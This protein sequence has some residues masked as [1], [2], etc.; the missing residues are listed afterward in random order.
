MQSIVALG[1]ETAKKGILQKLKQQT[2]LES[3]VEF[4]CAT[5]PRGKLRTL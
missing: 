2:G 1:E 5:S 4:G 3:D